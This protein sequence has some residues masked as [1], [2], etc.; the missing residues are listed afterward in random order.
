MLA[1]DYCS[2]TILIIENDVT[3]IDPLVEEIDQELGFK[4]LQANTVEDGIKLLKKEIIHC[5]VLD[6]S[7]VDRAYELDGL[8]ILD[9]LKSQN[10]M[11]PVIIITNYGTVY[12]VK[13]IFS[14]YRELH[15]E[16]EPKGLSAFWE[17]TISHIRDAIYSFSGINW[18]LKIN[19]SESLSITEMMQS[20]LLDVTS[21]EIELVELL[22]RSF[23]DA[24]EITIFP[25]SP[26]FSG[27]GVVKINPTIKLP[28]DQLHMGETI[29]LKYGKKQRIDKEAENYKKY[30]EL[31]VHHRTIMVDTPVYTS[32]LGAIRYTLIG[33]SIENT[34]SFSEYY[35]DADFNNIKTTLDKLFNQTCL[36]WYSDKS[37]KIIN[38]KE[39]YKFDHLR[40]RIEGWSMKNAPELMTEPIIKFPYLKKSYPNPFL[41]LDN[42][43]NS[44]RQIYLSITHGDL[45]G[46]NILVNVNTQ[47]SWLIDFYH[48]GISHIMTDFAKLESFVKLELIKNWNLE[49]YFICEEILLRQQ[50]LTDNIDFKKGTLPSNVEKMI[51]TVGIIRKS[52][53]QYS[54]PLTDIYPYLFA[55][56][57]K[58]ANALTFFTD[59]MSRRECVLLS[60]SLLGQRLRT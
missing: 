43:G 19:F 46:S 31:F 21:S 58:Y 5:I 48:T 11:I 13:E 2:P 35:K 12:N 42:I 40:R 14:K 39:E 47:E 38:L 45:N 34:I 25:L 23:K 32:K 6:L 57:Y 36:S 10:W 20:I 53:A 60:L 29:I 1:K 27:A 24:E 52:A 3:I 55:L 30:V 49:T 15:V 50:L 9:Y 41:L 7:L 44:S 54:H 28:D 59:D 56:F 8:L 17:S 37:K 4:S 33:S 18:D 51:N 16:V 22:A 26:G